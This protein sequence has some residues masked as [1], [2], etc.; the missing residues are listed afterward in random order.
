MYRMTNS[1]EMLDLRIDSVCLAEGRANPVDASKEPRTA[2]LSTLP[3]R[4]C[5]HSSAISLTPPE[6]SRESSTR[7]NRSSSPALVP[8]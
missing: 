6:Q 5:W 2:H 8:Q 1:S 4:L 3:R 7:L